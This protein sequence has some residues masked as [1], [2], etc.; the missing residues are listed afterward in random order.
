MSIILKLLHGLDLGH[1][2]V[3]KEIVMVPGCAKVV[4]KGYLFPLADAK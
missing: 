3:G 1:R 4:P 2:V